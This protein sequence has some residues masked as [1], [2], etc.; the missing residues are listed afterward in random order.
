VILIPVVCHSASTSRTDIRTT[1]YYDKSGTL[2][3]S[4]NVPLLIVVDTLCIVVSV[5]VYACFNEQCYKVECRNTDTVSEAKLTTTVNEQT[6]S[7]DSDLSTVTNK[8]STVT[9]SQTRPGIHC[10]LLYCSSSQIRLYLP[11]ALGTAKQMGPTAREYLPYF[12][13]S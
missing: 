12:P 6:S 10:T 13:Y 8:V 3:C 1:T 2:Q 9:D 11:K 4:C 7:A 5:S